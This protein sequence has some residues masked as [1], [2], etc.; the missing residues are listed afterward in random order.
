[1]FAGLPS[2]IA[3][4][5]KVGPYEVA[6]VGDEGSGEGV[7]VAAIPAAA[8]REAFSKDFA[9]EVAVFGGIC[10]VGLVVFCSKALLFTVVLYWEARNAPTGIE[11]RINTYTPKSSF[12]LK[13][14]N[15]GKGKGASVKGKVI[16]FSLSA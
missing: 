3:F 11:T 16:N 14:E 12:C 15:I 1:M 2:R 5:D 10:R 6:I 13:V 8:C 9:D 4:K 7:A